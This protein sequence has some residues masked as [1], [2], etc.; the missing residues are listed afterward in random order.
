[1]PNDVKSMFT[2]HV[3]WCVHRAIVT[4]LMVGPLLTVI[5][6][7]ERLWPFDPVWWKVALTFVVPFLVSLSGSLPGGRVGGGNKT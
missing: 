3:R 6:Q 1:M 4:M 7:W 5:N 2:P